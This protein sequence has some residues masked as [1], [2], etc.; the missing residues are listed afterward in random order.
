MRALDA[1][2]QP[3]CRWAPSVARSFVFCLASLYHPTWH[4]QGARPLLFAYNLIVATTLVLWGENAR[5]SFLVSVP[6]SP[7][8]CSSS[9]TH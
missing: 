9:A 4:C 8:V 2:L 3:G 5:D 7:K 1:T 6:F